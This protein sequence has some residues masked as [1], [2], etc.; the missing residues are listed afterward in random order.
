[1]KAS[2]RMR[3]STCSEVA[4]C[5]HCGVCC[6]DTE[7][8]LTEEDI[9]RIEGNT[10]LER[11]VFSYLADNGEMRLKNVDIDVTM[12][13]QNDKGL[14]KD[15]MK[16]NILINPSSGCSSVGGSSGIK[17]VA[18]WPGERHCIF[19]G[20]VVRLPQ[21]G[22]RKEGAGGREYERLNKS[23][24]DTGNEKEAWNRKRTDGFGV[25]ITFFCKIYP[26]RPEGCRYYPVILD[27]SSQLPYID[28]TCP[29]HEFFM[30]TWKKIKKN[31]DGLRGLVKRL[32][33]E[34]EERCMMKRGN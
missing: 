26:F 5:R 33:A 29:Y 21:A 11:G 23:G 12:E 17:M 4:P 1:M 34:A 19:L 9:R 7:M 15:E 6:F 32:T 3:S 8:P 24:M 31:P 22:L 2:K 25:E 13:M 30:K 16:K 10:G 14:L 20:I 27:I 18:E 28:D